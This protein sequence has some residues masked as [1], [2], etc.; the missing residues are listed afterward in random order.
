MILH[1]NYIYVTANQMFCEDHKK[2]TFAEG[3]YFHSI[4][5]F[6]DGPA[7]QSAADIVFVVDESGSMAF[8]HEWIQKAAVE[9]DQSLRLQG[10]GPVFEATRCWSGRKRKFVCSSGLWTK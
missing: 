9:L 4:E 5:T 2:Q 3:S 6:V 10:V 1:Y 8:E 7:S